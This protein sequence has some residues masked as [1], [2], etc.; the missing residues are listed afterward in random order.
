[1]TRAL[2]APL[3]PI[4]AAAIG[5]KNL[6]YDRGWLSSKRLAWPVIS[7]GNLSV[8]GAGK[9]P[10]VI[11]LA[12]LL[13]K[14]GVSV[15]VL[16]RGYG[17]DSDAVERVDENGAAE[18]FGDEPILIA[19]NARVP[20]YVGASRYDAGLL[21]EKEHG[22][23][24]SRVHLL[25][26]GFQHRRLARDVDIVVVHVSD[27][28]ARLLPAGRLREP[29]SAL[30]RAS[31]IVLRAE[32]RDREADL[33]RRGIDSPILIQ[34]RRMV[35]DSANWPLSFCGIARPE[36]FFAGLRGSGMEPVETQA[37]RDHHAY[38]GADIDELI[39]LLRTHRAESF[40]TTEK[41][42]VRMT[43][44]QRTRLAQAAPVSVARLEVVFEDE[45]ALTA[46]LLRLCV[47]K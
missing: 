34:N 8:G 15:D 16:S 32:D 23:S 47:R 22:S 24:D 42:W 6:A 36:E 20:V 33:R 45:A 31:V 29:L 2:L 4:Y 40:I 3:T 39:R 25:D 21:A 28:E 30:R 26:D 11:R 44:E 41:D 43:A 14:Q 10:V 27:F 5:A 18:R 19:R 9:T 38:S 1:M 13:A 35:V 37:Y 7:V 12:Q 17:R 46:Q